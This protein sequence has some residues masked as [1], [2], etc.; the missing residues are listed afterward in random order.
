[1]GALVFV[2][3][4]LAL[5]AI[6]AFAY[7][8][9]LVA[10]NQELVIQVNSVKFTMGDYVKLLKIYSTGTDASGSQN[11]ALAPFELLQV[12]EENELISQ[13]APRLGIEVTPEEIQK[14]IEGRVL[15]PTQEGEVIDPQTAARE[16]KERYRQR[17]TL[18]GLNDAEYRHTVRYDLA[19]SKL[20][21]QLGVAVPQ[22]A[23]Q[24]HLYGMLLDE[25]ANVDDLKAKLEKGADF[26]TL[27]KENSKDAN[28][29]PKGGDLGW[30]PRNVR[31]EFDGVIFGLA[32]NDVSFPIQTPEGYYLLKLISKSEDT[33]QL[34]A[35]FLKDNKEAF[36]VR[37]RW[38]KGE[39]FGALAQEVNQ[40]PVLR[41]K[42]GDLGTISRGYKDRVFDMAV[43]G[44]KPGTIIGPIVTTEGVWLLKITETSPAQQISEENRGVLKD[45]VLEDWLLEERRA[46]QV[47]RYFDSERYEW[48]IEQLNQERRPTPTPEAGQGSG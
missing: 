15:P 37:N 36:D 16:F 31:P 5:A 34:Q 45:R 25:Q 1:M 14:E 10:P 17:L 47:L 38:S 19:R 42:S 2:V 27:A 21:E 39:D 41:E 20:R 44:E 4:L 32:P 23:R 35:I 46:N 3:A 43:F 33:A 48:V 18:L 6:P 13:A 11:L 12:I 40:D 28:T 26:K 30:L 24:A 29:A 8:K 22:V 9:L 7:Y